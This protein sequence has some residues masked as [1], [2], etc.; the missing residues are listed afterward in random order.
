MKR[1]KNYTNLKWLR[2]YIYCNKENYNKKE[3]EFLLTKLD[4]ILNNYNYREGNINM[5]KIKEIYELVEKI[6]N[7]AIE[8]YKNN[9]NCD[10]FSDWENGYKTT[11]RNHDGKIVDY[12]S[13]NDFK[14]LYY[15][16][17]QTVTDKTNT[18][19]LNKV[20]EYLEKELQYIQKNVYSDKI[21]YHNL[22]RELYTIDDFEEMFE[23]DEE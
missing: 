2:N 18:V 12:I 11:F 9:I 1:M 13:Y 20:I 7:L 4:N 6:Q 21:E 15:N 14:S 16:L 3:W 19:V 8:N 5:N 10:D 17:T 22:D 23:G